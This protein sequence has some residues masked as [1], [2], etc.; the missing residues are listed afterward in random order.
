MKFK[1]EIGAIIV[2]V[3]VLALVVV[4]V[5]FNPA[6]ARTGP[7]STSTASVSGLVLS[8]TL[9]ASSIQTGHAISFSASLFNSLTTENNVTAA[10][11]WAVL[12]LVIGPCGPT[13]SP[14]AFAIVQGFYTGSN[15]SKAPAIQYGPSCTTV[16]GGVKLYSFRPMSD[17]ASV[18]G[19]CSTNPCFTKPMAWTRSFSNY[20]S[21]NE[22]VNF[23]PG[24]YTVVVADEWGN[25]VVAQFTVHASPA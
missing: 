5:Y 2:I 3:A 8:I 13:D 20:W 23:T 9:N 1:K 4:L 11:N 25:L 14:I 6:P 18:I 10:S 7:T 19:K 16:M 24:L 21:K 22:L 15:I 17:N 12:D